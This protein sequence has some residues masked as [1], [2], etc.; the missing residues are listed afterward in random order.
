MKVPDFNY[1][2]FIVKRILLVIL[3]YFFYRISFYFLNLAYLGHLSFP[4]V[5]GILFSGL[6]FDLSA[7]FVLNSLFIIWNTLPLHF[8]D[9]K[10]YRFVSDLVFYIP[11]LI[12]LMAN[13][14]D[15]VYFRFTLKRMTF[16]IFRYLQTDET[17]VNMIPKYF[18]DF[19][20][21]TLIFI[22][23][24]LAL[25]WFG[26]KIRLNPTNT[27]S[28]LWK[29][30]SIH[31]LIFLA[32]L[33][34][35]IILIRGGFQL[36]PISI[37]TAGEYTQAENT[38]FLLNTPFTIIKTFNQT[39]IEQYRF[40][41]RE[42]ADQL[43]N[44]VIDLNENQ[45]SVRSGFR[46]RNVVLI[47]LESFSLEHIGFFN[48]EKV[49][50][51]YTGFTPFF[52]SLCGQSLVFPEAFANGKR[53]IEGIPAIVASIP[54]WMDQAYITSNYAGNQI[55][56]LASL[57]KGEGYV[58]S[59]YHGGANGTMGFEAFTRM[60]GFEVYKGKNEYPHPS[61]DDGDWGIWDEPYLQYW[62]GELDHMDQ[63]FFSVVFTLSSHHPY[64]V[65]EKYQNQLPK[66]KLDIQQSIAYT[67][68]ALKNFFAKARNLPWFQN[69]LFVLTADHT[70]EAYLPEY[71]NRIGNF[72]IPIV[73][74]TPGKELMGMDSTV[75]SQVDIMPSIL[76]FLH[77]DRA[78]FAFGQSFFSRKYNPFAIS[79][80]NGNIQII[81]GSYALQWLDK[82]PVALYQYLQDP[83]LAENLIGNDIPAKSE[84]EMYLKAAIQ[85]YNFYMAGNK[86]VVENR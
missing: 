61:D 54:S 82:K 86:M 58:T 24:V 33:F 20:H 48:N 35:T 49:N 8:R 84:L 4:E 26:N 1:L 63:P 36:K 13:F 10:L 6:R 57:L 51:I 29:Y 62:A 74:Y 14:A 12:G 80:L 73:F 69:T 59:F 18:I 60:A 2:I 53:S 3:L 67:D 31:S 72:R 64:K 70:S 15:A 85:Q 39:G 7:I 41:S 28:V 44:P 81:K 52:D 43:F 47:I 66:G 76:D 55:N 25:F 50:G 23:F 65:P 56:S 5:T 34:I 32:S 83:L 75:I 68:L 45:D 38:P 30:L 40:F 77:Y 78:F 27:G 37:I 19:W 46:N 21:V 16:D 79:Y 11:N 9:K 17:S 42:E 22:V 71:Q